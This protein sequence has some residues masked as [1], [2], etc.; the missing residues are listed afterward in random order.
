[1]TRNSGL[2]KF[3]TSAIKSV[4]GDDAYNVSISSTKSM[5]GHAL[6]ASGGIET[7]ACIQAVRN[8]VI[9]PTINYENP[10]PEC[11]LDI[12]PNNAKEKA[13]KIAM[14]TNLGFGGHN[15][16]V[17]VKAFEYIEGLS[18]PNSENIR[19][20]LFLAQKKYELAYAQFKLALKRKVNSQNSLERIIPIS[21]MLKQWKDGLEYIDKLKVDPICCRHCC[22]C[23]GDRVALW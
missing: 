6:G 14:N 7:I 3:E 9:P 4:F 8:G 18:S 22:H 16:V 5:T 23:C 13:V 2:D 10:D 19:G 12:T 15:A 11:D 21:W 20:N 1:M 17:L